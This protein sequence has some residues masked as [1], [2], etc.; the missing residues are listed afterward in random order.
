MGEKIFSDCYHW[1]F[2]IVSSVV[3]FAATIKH[4]AFGNLFAVVVQEFE[5]ISKRLLSGLPL[6]TGR[7]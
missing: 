3:L 5:K 4:F 2:V 7:G 1:A 6:G